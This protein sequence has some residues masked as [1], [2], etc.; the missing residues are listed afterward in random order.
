MLPQMV[1]KH[2]LQQRKAGIM[3]HD[4]LRKPSFFL[5]AVM[6]I[7]VSAATASRATLT[8]PQ[9]KKSHS[10]Q[11]EAFDKDDISKVGSLINFVV[12]FLDFD[13]DLKNIQW[14]V[15]LCVCVVATKWINKSKRKITI[16]SHWDRVGIAFGGL[17]DCQTWRSGALACRW[18]RG[19]GAQRLSGS[20]AQ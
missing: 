11:K 7:A 15:V 12:S 10:V 20:V 3:D 14:V 6:V 16:Y 19:T 9:E 8:A 2:V 4:S 1:K 18:L 5:L 13:K 17:N